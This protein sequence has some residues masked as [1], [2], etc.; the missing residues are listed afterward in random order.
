MKRTGRTTKT[1]APTTSRGK[2]PLAST[3]GVE[4]ATYGL[5]GCH[6]IQLS[7][8]DSLVIIAHVKRLSIYL[9]SQTAKEIESKDARLLPEDDGVPFIRHR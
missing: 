4:P 3:T 1:K 5:G 7:Y 6:S 8:V 9:S 2:V